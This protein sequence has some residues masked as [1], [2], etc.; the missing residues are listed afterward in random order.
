V[1]S[2]TKNQYRLTVAWGD[3]DPAKLVF[4]P[5]YYRW[6]DEASYDLFKSV[7]LG[8]TDLREKYGAPGLPLISTHADFRSPSVFGDVLMVESWVSE[9]GIKS[10]T[11]SHVFTND[12]KDGR[13]AVEGWEKRVWSK[14]D[15]DGDGKLN[16]VPIPDEVKAAFGAA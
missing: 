15:L 13:I 16:P 1:S 7:G 5:N 10:L 14:G 11:I 3:C 9:W 2:I 6:M 8:W 4:Y 12:T